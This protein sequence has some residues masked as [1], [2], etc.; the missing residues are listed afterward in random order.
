M[1]LT[2]G[3]MNSPDPHISLI[4]KALR[5]P[6]RMIPSGT[7]MPILRGPMRG[8]RWIV[9]SSNHGC[10]LGTYEHSKQKLFSAT[11]QPNDVVYD[12]GANVGYYSLLASVLVG[13]H[14]HVFSFEPAPRNLGLL[15]RHL[16]LNRIENCS[17]FDVAVSSSNGT[18]RFDFG[19][20]PHMGHLAGDS[21]NT[22]SMRTVALD[23]LVA[24]GQIKPPNLIKCDIEGGELDAL[25]GAAETLS[26]YAPSIFLAT[27]GPKVHEDCCNLLTH[28]GYHLTPLDGIS[29]KDATEILAVRR[30]SLA[31]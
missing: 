8:K 20:D 5:L 2:G 30:A 26:E 4:G 17:V 7:L 19:P 18:A 12:L 13:P 24:S 6:L 29:L 15:R 14:G 1:D 25:T 10:W 28:L 3:L 27:H 11:I 23:S 31:E 22:V 9:G 21:E 16:Q